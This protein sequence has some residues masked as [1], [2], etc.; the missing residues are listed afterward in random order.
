V[1]VLGGTALLEHVT[2]IANQAWE[3]GAIINNPG[4]QVKLMNSVVTRNSSLEDGGGIYNSGTLIIQASEI[5]NNS[6]RSTVFG[7]GGIYNE[8]GQVTLDHS[9][10][11]GNL[12]LEGGGL[13]N[14]GGTVT[15]LD[16]S[17][18]SGNVAT[19]K[20]AF[21]PHG[22]GGINN[23]SSGAVTIDQ[24]FVIWN[25]AAGTTGGGIYNQA[26]LKV[27]GSVLAGNL[28]GSGGAVFNDSDGTGSISSSCILDN[29]VV[30]AH[31]AGLGNGIV[32]DNSAAFDARQNWWGTHAGPG[33][34]LSAGV[35]GAPY[36]NAAAGLC[37]SALP[38]P[39]PTP[40]GP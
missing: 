38:T 30:L 6:S 34:S 14:D 32:N 13:Y 17:V 35:T 22:G 10:L 26:S 20:A 8:N 36:L 31:T 12:A 27:T 25:Q 9:Q 37:A 4:T 24:S 28:A 7:G 33:D 39:F 2:L 23:I 11:L 40:A 29:Q 1:D 19:E 16:Q 21:I 3:G 5:S 15:I 18:I